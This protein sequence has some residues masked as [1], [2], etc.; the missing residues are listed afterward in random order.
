MKEWD[1][2]L[3]LNT[4]GLHVKM[5]NQ[6]NPLGDDPRHEDWVP[7]KLRAHREKKKREQRGQLSEKE[8]GNFN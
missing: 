1:S 7:P 8:I 2:Q 6:A 4:E 5:V 3:K